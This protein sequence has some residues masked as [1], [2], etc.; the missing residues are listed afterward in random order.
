MRS[1]EKCEHGCDAGLCKDETCPGYWLD[2]DDP[3]V[4]ALLD[5]VYAE[6]WL[7][8]AQRDHG[9]EQD[10]WPQRDNDPASRESDHCQG[11]SLALLL[12]AHACSWLWSSVSRSASSARAF[13][14]SRSPASSARCTS[15]SAT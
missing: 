5:D 7:G 6:A 12:P 3:K 4:A 13:A 15:K 10:E 14:F 9:R 8:H 2:A 11:G 1:G